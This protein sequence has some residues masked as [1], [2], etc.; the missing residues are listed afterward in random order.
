[1]SACALVL[2]TG[3]VGAT[4]AGT[5]GTAPPAGTASLGASP[6]TTASASVLALRRAVKS[7]GEALGGGA[8]DAVREGLKV[9]AANSVAYHYLEH[10]VDMSQAALDAGQPQPKS[11]ALPVGDD[12]FKFC[13]TPSN[14]FTC[15]TFGDFKVDGGGKLVDFT[16]NKQAVGPRLTVSSGQPVTAAGVRF[17]F[18]SAYK[19]I[20]SN[21]LALT[22]QVES[23][24]Q[25]ITVN[26]KLWSY[27]GS[28]GKPLATMGSSGATYV[29]DKSK[30]IVSMVFESGKAGGSLTLGGCRSTDCPGGSF[31]AVLKVG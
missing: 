1:V 23:G 22:V 16:I 2:L 25:P 27:R 5:L 31:S 18:L 30:T 14:D 10:V 9:T 8:P 26:P 21:F 17:T 29:L 12:A 11:T 4:Q 20:V 3:C 24:A 15:A 19:S 13:T 28:D 7:Y 6:A